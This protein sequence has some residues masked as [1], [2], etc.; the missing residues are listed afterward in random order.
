MSEFRVDPEKVVNILY[1]NWQGK[2]AIRHIV[3]IEVK[4]ETSEWH[5]EPQWIL[6]AWDVEKDARRSFAMKD[7]RSWFL[8]K[9]NRETN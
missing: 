3:P 9:Q 2:T 5:P 8:D 1:T 4:W 6:D 7:I